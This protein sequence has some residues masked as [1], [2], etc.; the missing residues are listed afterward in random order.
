MSQ[1]CWV[2]VAKKGE[3]E[4]E[5]CVCSCG[6][7]HGEA[8]KG[9]LEPGTLSGAWLLVYHLPISL[10]PQIKFHLN[11]LPIPES[12]CGHLIDL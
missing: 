9:L 3:K 12:C 1:S 6:G 10:E 7:A 4:A 2:V 5:G 11:S 8:R